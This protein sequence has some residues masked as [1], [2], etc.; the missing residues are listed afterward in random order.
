MGY[1]KIYIVENV[2]KIGLTRYFFHE[3]KAKKKATTFYF[4]Q[5]KLGR[6]G[7]F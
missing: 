5:A 6:F 7:L 1:S 2:S 3:K 4:Q